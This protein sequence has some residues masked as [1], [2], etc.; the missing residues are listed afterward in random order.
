[1]QVIHVHA[2]GA[3]SEYD[4]A[5]IKLVL[6]MVEGVRDIAA[7]PSLGLISVLYDDDRSDATDIVEAV[8]S[9]GFDARECRP[10]DVGVA[11]AAAA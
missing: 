6:G 2:G 7:V 8:C 1:M 9:A 11:A 3:S 10:H 4:A 5:F